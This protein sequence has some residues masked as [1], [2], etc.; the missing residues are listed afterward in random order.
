M[1]G[2]FYD[3]NTLD[4]VHLDQPYYD[5]NSV[6]DLSIRHKNYFVSGDL[7]LL[8]YTCTSAIAFNK[9]L[10]KEYDLENPYLLV[11]NRLWTLDKML[12][13]M[14]YT[15]NLMGSQANKNYLEPRLK[16]MRE[17]LNKMK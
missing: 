1:D 2:F 15:D 4:H 9:D 17:L 6:R 10:I 16:E 7:C 14:R 3:L 12:E 13:Y 8:S 11:E 5:Q